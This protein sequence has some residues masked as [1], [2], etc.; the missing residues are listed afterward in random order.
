MHDCPFLQFGSCLPVFVASCSALRSTSGEKRPF[1]SSNDTRKLVSISTH[2]SDALPAPHATR[3]ASNRSL[4]RCS[5]PTCG[6]GLSCSCYGVVVD[7]AR[8][9]CRRNFHHPALSVRSST[10]P[11]VVSFVLSAPTWSFHATRRVCF[12][13]SIQHGHVS[14]VCLE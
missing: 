2:L 9:S 8:V 5:N 4:I 10:R 7:A 11:P 14:G 13:V 6:S 3:S 12:L 1:V